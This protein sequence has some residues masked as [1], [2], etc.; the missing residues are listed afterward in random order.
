[1]ILTNKNNL[2]SIQPFRFNQ[3][4]MEVFCIQLSLKKTYV[5][6][7]NNNFMFIAVQRRILIEMFSIHKMNFKILKIIHFKLT[8]SVV[9]FNS[10]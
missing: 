2:P 3:T 7:R 4:I 5:F 1:M 8:F 6:S 9:A 10:I